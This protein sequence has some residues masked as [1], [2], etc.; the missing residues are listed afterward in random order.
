MIVD[1]TARWC[2]VCKKIERTVFADPAVRRRLE[3]VVLAQ[4]DLST[5]PDRAEGGTI[6]VLGRTFTL[7]GLPRILLFDRRG[8]LWRDWNGPPPAGR[9]PPDQPQDVL[10]ALDAM[11]GAP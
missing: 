2:G 6:V 4:I 9:P 11:G 3:D 7:H 5:D 10:E 8:E 1:V